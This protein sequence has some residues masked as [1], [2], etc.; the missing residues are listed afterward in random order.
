MANTAGGGGTL[1]L[2]ASAIGDEEVH[3][4][5]ALLRNEKRITGLNLR[6]NTITDLGARALAALISSTCP[7]RTVDLRRNHISKNGVRALAEASG[8]L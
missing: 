2:P 8:T 6:D 1:Q 7:L 4:I 5:V 3:A